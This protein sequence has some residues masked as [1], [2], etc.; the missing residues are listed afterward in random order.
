MFPFEYP[1]QWGLDF[2]QNT[3]ADEQLLS[4]KSQLLL[5]GLSSRN[6]RFYM[7]LND[8]EKKTVRAMDIL[9]PKITN[10]WCSQREE[11]L[12]VLGAKNS[13]QGPNPADGG[14]IWILRRYGT[15]YAGFGL[16]FERLYSL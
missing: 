6:Q 4:S 13:N 1:V 9:A 7:R 10:Y 8:D 11:R 14:G 12:D 15:G 2:N 3:S 5:T 16:G